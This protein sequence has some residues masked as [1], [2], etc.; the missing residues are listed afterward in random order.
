MI[1][2]INNTVINR[3]ADNNTMVT[4]KGVQ[5]SMWRKIHNNNKNNNISNKI[6]I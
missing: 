1:K 5:Y 4:L 2:R 3:A 6:T